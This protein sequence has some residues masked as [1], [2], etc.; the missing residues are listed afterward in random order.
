MKT[1][2]IIAGLKRRMAYPDRPGQTGINAALRRMDPA[3]P[4]ASATAA[5]RAMA[6]AGMDLDKLHP[7]QMPAWLLIVHTMALARWRHDSSKPVGQGLVAMNFSEN[8]LKQLLSADF[9]TLQQLLPRL[10]RR[11]AG[12]TDVPGM[13]FTPLARLALAANASPDKLEKTRLDVALSYTRFQ[14][15]TNTEK[16][17][18]S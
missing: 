2:E 17:K 7:G 4:G 14:N 1:Y 13:D 9:N 11:F 18:A 15:Q 5:F 3:H 10:A 16:R 12:C 8:R 6:D